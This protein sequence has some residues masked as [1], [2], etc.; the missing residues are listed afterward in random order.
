[1]VKQRN[2]PWMT[3]VMNMGIMETTAITEAMMNMAP[4][5]SVMQGKPSVMNLT[6]A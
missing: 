2:P 3:M 4:K 1:M 5:T 6:L